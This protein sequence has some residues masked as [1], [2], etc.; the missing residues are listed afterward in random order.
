M[1]Q[2][3]APRFWRRSGL[4][5]LWLAAVLVAV[6]NLAS[7]APSVERTARSTEGQ[8]GPQ[9]HA[10]A[11]WLATRPA[12]ERL[13]LLLPPHV[14]FGE[15]AEVFEIRLCHLIYPRRADVVFGHLPPGA[16]GAYD[17]IVAY[18]A[19]EATQ[20]PESWTRAASNGPV[21]L[22][23]SP[24]AATPLGRHQPQSDAE[25]GARRFP[26]ALGLVGASLSLV[27]TYLF[28]ALLLTSLLPAPP[29]SGWPANLAAAHLVGAAVVAWLETTWLALAG[30][31][32]VIPVY[33]GLALTVA[34]W[35]RNRKWSVF[36]KSAEPETDQPSLP[37]RL[38][39]AAVV[40]LGALFAIR[41]AA[42]Q[43]FGWDGWAL[44]QLKARA[45][46]MDGSAA[47]LSDSNHYDTAHLD[48]PLLVPILSWWTYTHFGAAAAFL[49]QAIGFLFYV[50]LLVL[51]AAYASLRTSGLAWRCAVALLACLPVAT[52]H[53]GSGFA[54]IEFTAYLL[55]AGAALLRALKER[56]RWSL[57]LACAFLA[58][59]VQ[60]KNEGMLA[61]V[62]VTA[63]AA[64]TYWR[65]RDKELYRSCGALIGTALAAYLPWLLM[66]QSLHLSSDLF[67]ADRATWPADTGAL[68]VFLLV[69]L[70]YGQWHG[71][72]DQ[73]ANV[74]LWGLVGILA[75]AGVVC[76]L[77][78]RGA[79]A[80]ALWWLAVIQWA[81]YLFIYVI[82][83]WPLP[84]HVGTSAD[85]LTLHLT[86][87]LLLAAT[88]TCFGSPEALSAPETQNAA[89]AGAAFEAGRRGGKRSGRQ[90]RR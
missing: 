55:A 43:G 71:F 3:P 80:A 47:I 87:L 77:K 86:P 33:I 27:V 75:L 13:L 89:P 44:W 51:F 26:L 31:L 37:W 88:I 59:I 48:Y 49:A 60:T 8:F 34:W 67:A 45:F 12:G 30:S 81:G 56:D 73:I 65:C 17:A 90:A 23:L 85:R 36:Q 32:S 57:Y 15:P 25:P 39:L 84:F 72:L 78:R 18:G 61:T 14:Y 58:G 54:D 6:V 40:L 66:K 10:A 69:R 52:F 74:H 7:W 4:T 63:V 29:F 64:M 5:A 46:W 19:P 24:A 28:G 42:L 53:A 79:P 68:A 1:V 82:T 83:P 16:E 41:Q 70:I 76:G 21:V 11:S 35:R 22:A 2:N 50:D 9:T 20:L 38:L 62:G